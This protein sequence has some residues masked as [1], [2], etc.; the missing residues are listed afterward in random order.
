[1]MHDMASREGVAP[2]RLFFVHGDRTIYDYDSPTSI[3]L[4]VADI[5]GN[6]L[7]RFLCRKMMFKYNE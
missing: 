4:H 7:R 6:S 5:L 2:D 3:Q 1:M